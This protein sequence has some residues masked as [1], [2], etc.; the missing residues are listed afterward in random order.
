MRELIPFI[1]LKAL[2]CLNFSQGEVVYISPSPS[3]NDIKSKLCF[4]L[5][6]LA[7]NISWLDSNTTLIFLSGTHTLSVEFSIINISSLSLLS[8]STSLLEQ[9]SLKS[10]V[11]CQLNASFYFHDVI[12]ISISGLKL[13]S[14]RLHA[15]LIKQLLIKRVTF[16][17]KNDSGTALEIVTT[18]ASIT[19]SAFKYNRIGRCIIFNP[20]Q[21]MTVITLVGGAIFATN[22]S[23]ISIITSRF[24]SN[25]AEIGGAIYAEKRCHMTIL[26]STFIDN[27]VAVYDITKNNLYSGTATAKSLYGSS[28]LQSFA[29]EKFIQPYSPRFNGRFCMGGAIA[30]IQSTLLVDNCVFSNNTSKAGEAGVLAVQSNSHV[31]ICN[32]KFYNS[33]VEMTFGGA[34][35]VADQSHM[36]IDNSTIYNCS[37][38]YQ[39]SVV[40]V[41]I[42]SYLTIKNSILNGSSAVG[43]GGVVKLSDN[44]HLKISSSQFINNL[45][46]S[47]G[48]MAAYNSTVSIEGNNTLFLMNKA[49][50]FGGVM[51]I[52]Q[53]VL[54]LK[55]TSIFK[56]NQAKAGGAICSEESTVKIFGEVMVVSNAASISGGSLY[57]YHSMFSCRQGSTFNMVSNRANHCGGGV[58]AT[59]SFITIYHNR[60]SFIGSLVQFVNN[61]ATMGGGICLES[62]SQ[63]RIYKR[64]S[65]SESETRP[66]HFKFN[67]AN[68]GDA[69][70]VNDETYF[71]V[72]SR[73]TYSSISSRST[74][75]FV[76][77][78]SPQATF[79]HRYELITLDFAMSN[80]SETVG[81][82]TIYGGLLDRC[83]IN[84]YAEVATKHLDTVIHVYGATYWKLITNLNDTSR[85]SSAPVRLCFCNPLDD[86]PDCNYKPSQVRVM[87]GEIFNISLVAVDQV[88]HTV[89]NAIIYSSLSNPESGLGQGQ[90]VQ[91]TTN[92]CTKLNFS[93]SSPHSFEQLILY[94]DGPCRNVSR[95]QSR[96]NIAFK[97][98][99]CP[100]IGFQ[101]KNNDSEA[102]TCECGCDSRLY[103]FITG[104]MCNYQ[105]GV[106]Q[107]NGNFWITYMDDD[108]AT[109]SGY[110]IYPHCPLDYCIP[111]VPINLNNGSGDLQ[112]AKNRSGTLCGSCKPNFSVSFGS[113]MCLQCSTQ[114]YKTFP[115]LLTIG[116][117]FGIALVAFLMVLNLT[118]AVGSLNGLIF[119][120]NILGT[121]I[122][123]SAKIPSVF[124]SLLN[125]QVGFDICL[126]EGMDTYWKTWLQ[127][128]FPSYV[129][130]IVIIIIIVSNHSMN[131]SQLLAKRDPVATLA[132]LTLLSYTMFLRTTIA[133]LSFAKL[134][135]PN[136]FYK[137][138]WLHDGTVE[139]LRGKHVTLFVAA[140]L[141]ITVGIIYTFLLFFWPWLLRYQNKFIF[142]WARSQK[143]Q[144]FIA[145]YHAPYNTG[146]RYWT[147]LLLIVRIA[148]NLVFALN[149]SNDPGLNLLAIVVLVG[150]V[151]FLRAYVGRIYKSSIVDR[152]EIMCYS[153]AV[154][155]SSIQL[156]LLKT[157]TMKVIDATAYV[158]GVVIMILFF[159]IIF[160]HMWREC[161]ARCFRKCKRR[162]IL[163]QDSVF[164]NDKN[165]ADYPPLTGKCPK[166]A[167]TFTVIEGPT[168][169]DTNTISTTHDDSL[170]DNSS[171]STTLLLEQA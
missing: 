93:I 106:L 138:V 3:C 125:L 145:P 116:F 101:V 46:G 38:A 70:Y 143:L 169:S 57:L 124:V 121:V 34:F 91:K 37:G 64:G 108:L 20:L 43:S 76:Q 147:G 28:L 30:L 48:V 39:G 15:V 61:S 7:T 164:E 25:C 55:G 35:S 69:I 144:H 75:C 96:L 140:I 58:Y 113:S 11:T 47:G 86:K 71:D 73:S 2:L 167:P 158:C 89:R 74:E 109:S 52:F 19:S 65:F 112:C 134:E 149:V 163:E 50:K 5:D 152:I 63:F 81:S 123:S 148:L 135:Y 32:S 16:Q 97:N 12:Y 21:N 77:V 151:L 162:R 155:F 118:V 160:Y 128:A 40:D 23:N 157:G 13:V 18:N 62:S 154:L 139:C 129:I 127:L 115:V 120:A 31:K 107:R 41:Y 137:Y 27:H 51:Y 95:S 168:H 156:Y 79:T 159:I 110:V 102:N 45:A 22:Y 90:M 170:L 161:D 153:S 111:N 150:A 132:T 6:E 103:P 53:S 56:K 80:R 133:V 166:A 1:F 10:I 85:I 92:T 26:K 104:S 100:K 42:R 60:Q 14:C 146:H 44:C 141:I 131:F 4:S 87:K 72:C 67:F 165:L 17:G 49:T 54:I 136:N 117:V 171:D 105:T 24:E 114:W 130:L 83:T 78:L 122:P 8:Q 59:N 68:F 82:T 119:Y 66:V 9:S 29:K 126:F 88:N 84:G 142:R 94:P 36:I 98:C 99:I 33:H